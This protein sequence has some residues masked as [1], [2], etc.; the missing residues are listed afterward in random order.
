V[1]K[2]LQIDFQFRAPKQIEIAQ[3]NQSESCKSLHLI[4][5]GSAALLVFRGGKASDRTVGG[6]RD[7]AAA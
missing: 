6:Q 4:E 7:R 1:E 3:T 5:A 2:K